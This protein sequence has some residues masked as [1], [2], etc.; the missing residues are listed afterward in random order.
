[1]YHHYICSVSMCLLLLLLV[2]YYQTRAE[3]GRAGPRNRLSQT[4]R[5]GPPGTDRKIDGLGWA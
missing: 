5:A 1:M 2:V 3:S 4:G